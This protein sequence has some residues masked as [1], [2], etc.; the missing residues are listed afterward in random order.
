LYGLPRLLGLHDAPEVMYANDPV[1]VTGRLQWEQY[2]PCTSI[3]SYAL[4][5]LYRKYRKKPPTLKLPDQVYMLG[6][7]GPKGS[8]VNA[9]R[10]PSRW[11]RK[12]MSE[13]VKARGRDLRQARVTG[14]LIRGRHRQMINDTLHILGI[15]RE[16]VDPA[17]WKKIEEYFEIRRDGTINLVKPDGLKDY[18][19]KSMKGKIILSNGKGPQAGRLTMVTDGNVMPGFELRRQIAAQ[20]ADVAF[21]AGGVAEAMVI[22]RAV[23]DDVEFSGTI[24][25]YLATEDGKENA[26]QANDPEARLLRIGQTTKQKSVNELVICEKAGL[27]LEPVSRT[28]LLVERLV[29]KIID[30]ASYT[31]TSVRDILKSWKKEKG[32]LYARVAPFDKETLTGGRYNLT[33]MTTPL[34]DTETKDSDVIPGMKEVTP[35]PDGRF[36]TVT[37]LTVDPS[38]RTSLIPIVYETKLAD[39]EGR[40]L[41]AKDDAERMV[42]LSLIGRLYGDLRMYGEAEQAFEKATQLGI[43][44]DDRLQGMRAYYQGMQELLKKEKPI[45]DE[46]KALFRRSSEHGYV[47]GRMMLEVIDHGDA[48]TVQPAK[49]VDAIDIVVKAPEEGRARAVDSLMAA[50]SQLDLEHRFTL[51]LLLHSIARY[52]VPPNADGGPREFVH[53]M[54]EAI[55]RNEPMSESMI[56]LLRELAADES[57]VLYFREELRM[58]LDRHG[59]SGWDANVR[60]PV[61]GKWAGLAVAAM[62]FEEWGTYLLA[63]LFGYHPFRPVVSAA[64]EEGSYVQVPEAERKPL[65]FRTFFLALA[66]PAIFGA[67]AYFTGKAEWSLLHFSWLAVLGSWAIM[68]AL[69]YGIRGFSDDRR[70]LSLPLVTMGLIAGSLAAIANLPVF[71][72]SLIA[73]FILTQSAISLLFHLVG[74]RTPDREHL[75]QAD[76]LYRVRYY[77]SKKLPWLGWLLGRDLPAPVGD[78]LRS[79]VQGDRINTRETSQS[80]PPH[81]DVALERA[82]AIL[83]LELIRNIGT[84]AKQRFNRTITGADYMNLVVEALRDLPNDA[85]PHLARPT[86]TLPNPNYTTLSIEIPVL[87][88]GECQYVL[89][90]LRKPSPEKDTRPL[91]EEPDARV[92]E[93]FDLSGSDWTSATLYEMS[94]SVVHFGTYEGFIIC[95]FHADQYRD[96]EFVSGQKEHAAIFADAA[97]REAMRDGADDHDTSLFKDLAA[98]VRALGEDIGMPGLSIGEG[99]VISLYL[100]WV[101]HYVFYLPSELPF[102]PTIRI[103]GFSLNA[104]TPESRLAVLKLAQR[105]GITNLIRDWMDHD[106]KAL[107]HRLSTSA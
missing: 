39:L 54:L 64:N 97:R 72:E 27:A 71:V 7:W 63:K 58:A 28:R 21:G 47:H 51:R 26:T 24:I 70:P 100:D 87:V 75:D 107:A 88:F 13:A 20:E 46:A 25:S 98:T 86:A 22:T 14:M 105:Y 106:F 15:R 8:R 2:L 34:G 101:D 65:A 17:L 31:Q 53:R 73:G 81:Q 77:L 99:I 57:T 43:P 19:M 103:A 79:S 83:R 89:R 45:I 12:N 69:L 6:V 60:S 90:L 94:R 18:V 5:K 33:L 80:W 68:P 3:A 48:R 82:R 4:L 32:V 41:N 56:P 61:R 76:D 49:L 96:T 95:R 62:A 50:I 10:R 36:V 85:H 102:L 84:V 91:K 9:L 66:F 59:L 35:S 23:Y 40:L 78:K 44:A 38:G 1:E 30:P 55:L 93:R 29:H 16:H 11:V 92:V 67:L 104:L 74:W 52:R 37:A 42:V